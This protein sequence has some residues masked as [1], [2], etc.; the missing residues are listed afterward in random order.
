M[1]LNFSILPR[2]LALAA[3]SA[4]LAASCALAANSTVKGT[5]VKDDGSPADFVDVTLEGGNPPQVQTTMTDEVGAFSFSP[6]DVG[7][8]KLYAFSTGFTS[9]VLEGIEIAS[10]ETKTYTIKLLAAKQAKEEV[11]KVKAS[12]IDLVDVKKTDNSATLTAKFIDSLPLQNKRLQDIVALFAGVTRSGSSDSTDISIQGGNSSQIGYRLNGA[13]LNDPVNGGSL[14]D[15]PTASIA[16]FKLITGGF[17]A[18]YGEQSTGIAEVVTKSGTNT[19]DSSYYVDY[20]DASWGAVKQDGL[21]DVQATWNDLLTGVGTALQDDMA[22]GFQLLGVDPISTLEDDSNPADRIRIRQGISTSGPIVKDKVYYASTLEA[23]V[24]DFGSPYVEGDVQN[25]Q[26]LFTGKI[27]WTVSESNKLDATFSVDVSDNSGI[28]F[29]NTTDTI[30]TD[31]LAGTWQLNVNDTH[32]FD[33]SSF[34]ETRLTLTHDYTSVRPVD[35]RAGVGTQYVI[36][37]PPGG[38]QSYFV[39]NAN[40]DFDETIN[41]ARV[42]SAFTKTLTKHTLKMGGALQGNTFRSYVKSGA[43]VSDFRVADDR[44]NLLGT[45]PPFVG[46]LTDSGPPVETDDS[47]W[48]TYVFMQDKWN[49]TKNLTLDLGLRADYQA[50]VG[51]VFLAPRVGFSLDPIGDNKTRFFGN[52][53]IFYDNLFANALQHE[54]NPDEFVSE[55]YFADAFTSARKFSQT[56]IDVIFKE[57]LATPY[58]SQSV[59]AVAYLAPNIHDR[60]VL[61]DELSAPTNYSWSTGIERRLPGQVRFQL[62]YQEARRTHQLQTRTEVVRASTNLGEFTVRDVILESRGKGAFQSWTT[63]IQKAFADKWT[64]NMSWVQQRNTGPIAPSANSLDPNDV[65]T[66]NGLLG[67]DRTNVIKLQGNGKL[68]PNKLKLEVS[69][70]FVWQEGTP[71]SAEVITSGGDVIRPFGRN[72]LRLPPSRQLNF[73]LRRRFETADKKLKVTGEFSVFNLLNELN[74]VTGLGR[75]QLPEGISSPLDYPPYRPVVQP[76]GVDVPLSAQVGVSVEF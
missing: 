76:L 30:D 8:Y 35:K 52:W 54:Q 19:L 69:A 46:R 12:L 44:G 40:V 47:T 37:L 55:I 9:Q 13:S 42:E 10:N 48:Q 56:P 62:S 64:V 70:D 27:D 39:G 23:L 20:R 2:A 60:F 1:N 74:V 16:S 43:T 34:L 14:L 3:A 51:E 65:L 4:A 59:D 29:I 67:N 71:I 49:V 57:A 53:G 24:D 18:E 50:F 75:F 17:S 32:T 66:E 38:F 25:D 5:V 58:D 31:A 61:S 68:W 7:S 15:I 33:K 11:V 63:E 26:L 21:E 36:P 45:P 22:R 28:A 72:T 41:V 73:G 6:V